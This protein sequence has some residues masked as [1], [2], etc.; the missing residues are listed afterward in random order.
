[1]D[2]EWEPSA[3]KMVAEEQGARF[4]VECVRI[5]LE[6]PD[7]EGPH[8][9]PRNDNPPSVENSRRAMTELLVK[10]LGD[11]SK[12]LIH[13]DEHRSMCDRDRTVDNDPGSPE[14]RCGYWPA[15]TTPH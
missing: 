12:A 6:Q 11:D 4:A 7:K 9:V 10:H 1:M 15:H 13:V 2:R 14:E 8:K 3:N 5:L